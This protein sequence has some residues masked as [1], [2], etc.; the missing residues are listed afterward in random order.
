MAIK[1]NTSATINRVSEALGEHCRRTQEDMERL[2]TAAGCDPKKVKMLD[3]V[4]PMIP[5]SKDDVQ[6][7]G[8]N[9]VRFYF[10]RGIPIK[11]PEPC[12][13]ILHNCGLA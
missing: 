13:E 2:L 4:L 12:Y 11:V 7:V 1:T 8:F 6:F 9:G 10:Q 5:G 3:M